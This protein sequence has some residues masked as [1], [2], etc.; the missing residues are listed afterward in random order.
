MAP[1]PPGFALTGIVKGTNV[2]YEIRN[3]QLPR[4]C[5]EE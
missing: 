3:V 1:L 2:A 4:Q 5:E